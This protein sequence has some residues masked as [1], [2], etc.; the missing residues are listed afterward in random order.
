M[1]PPLCHILCWS[2][3]ATNYTTDNALQGYFIITAFRALLC[4]WI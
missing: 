2:L 3:E 1:P 4:V